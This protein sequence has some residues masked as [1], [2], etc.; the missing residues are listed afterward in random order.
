MNQPVSCPCYRL[1]RHQLIPIS[2][3]LS[4]FN[5]DSH[6]TFRFPALLVDSSSSLTLS[7]SVLLSASPAG[8]PPLLWQTLVARHN[9]SQLRAIRAICCGAGGSATV[10]AAASERIVVGTPGMRNG[11]LVQTRAHVQAAPTPAQTDSAHASPVHLLQGPPGT[12]TRARVEANIFI[13]GGRTYAYLSALRILF[14][15]SLP[16]FLPCLCL[17]ILLR[18][19]THIVTSP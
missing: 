9:P 17:S 10:T 7:D 8:V 11:A 13:E 4:V 2:I 1:H 6:F 14:L 19:Y 15:W 16:S 5:A 18:A 12:N 3:D